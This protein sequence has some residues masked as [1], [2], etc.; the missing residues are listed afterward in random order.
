MRVIHQLISY[1]HER[2]RFTEAQLEEF[3]KKGFWGLYN[4][5]D[6]YSLE[7]KIG[8]SFF[9]QV[10]GETHGPLWGTDV[11]TSDSSLG[12]AC[13]HAGILKAGETEVVKLT[14]VKPLSVFKGSTRHGVISDTWT[15]S[16]SGAYTVEAFKP[17][18]AAV[19]SPKPP[20]PKK[21]K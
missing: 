12:A 19:A 15:T 1:F 13:V 3:V 10:T 14:M 11:Y 18:S 4:A 17:G 6:L 20:G 2:E 21:R 9:F 8:E 5:D 16:W 7:K